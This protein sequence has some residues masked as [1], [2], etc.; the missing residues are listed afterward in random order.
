MLPLGFGFAALALVVYG[1]ALPGTPAS[2]DVMFFD[3]PYLQELSAHNLIEILDP[4]GQAH[5]GFFNYAP[6]HALLHALEMRLFGAE[7]V[8]FHVVNALLHAGVSALLALLLLRSG[9]PASGALLGALVFLLHPANVEAVAWIS[10][11]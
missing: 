7:Y 3:S 8:G 9:L 5:L 1:P 4:T 10:Q 11:L 6:V 2:D